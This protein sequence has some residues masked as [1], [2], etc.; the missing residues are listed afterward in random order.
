MKKTRS[1]IQI[2]TA[3]LLL[4][5]FSSC[6]DSL[7]PDTPV[8]NRRTM[9]LYSAGYNSLSSELL[10]DIEDICDNYLPAGDRK[11]RDNLFIFSHHTAGSDYNWT[12][13]SAPH[14]IR[15]S[16]AGQKIYRDT[17]QTYSPDT[18]AVDP[19]TFR[20]VL[21]YIR[22]N[23][24]SGEYG[25]IFSSHATGWL[26]P[27]F[28]LDGDVSNYP[29]ARSGSAGGPQKSLGQDGGTKEEMDVK[30]FAAAIPMHM[31]YMI[32]DSCLAGGVEVAY[33]LREK[34]DRIVFSQE[35]ILADGFDYVNITRR[36]LGEYPSNVTGVAEDFFNHY[37]SKTGIE[38]SATISV[39]DCQGLDALTGVCRDIFSKYREHLRD[40]NPSRVQSLNHSSDFF[41]DF[42][43]IIGQL[44]LSAEE[45]TALDAALEA[46]IPYKAH[47]EKFFNL[48]IGTFSGL[49]MYLP[50]AAG[51]QAREILD[52]YYLD[53][54][55]NRAT[56]YVSM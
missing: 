15:I 46:C 14:L 3:C 53:F 32:F 18:K 27:E 10:D 11:Y 24:S 20:E 41:Y 30:D 55:W 43:D 19:D 25:L 51:K 40:I 28:P 52:E 37:N 26:P 49:S 34:C 2:F 21:T 8:T 42:R 16:R 48:A 22:D 38:Q 56:D 5:M 23:F 45:E 6:G 50:N 39:V 44:G 17:I 33:E 36:L 54:A 12:E 35:E 9:I 4:S 7:A 1:L 31:K 47:T 13:P 29:Y